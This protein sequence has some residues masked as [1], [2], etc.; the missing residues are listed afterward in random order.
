MKKLQSKQGLTM[1]CNHFTLQSWDC[2]FAYENWYPLDRVD[3]RVHSYR[4]F[5]KFSTKKC[6]LTTPKKEILLVL[7]E[8]LFRSISAYGLFKCYFPNTTMLLA[9]FL[10]IVHLEECVRKNNIVHPV[11]FGVCL[12]LRIDIEEYLRISRAFVVKT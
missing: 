4:L 6:E 8:M 10:T 5:A 12:K 2:V 1:K 9:S 7:H 3:P 11:H